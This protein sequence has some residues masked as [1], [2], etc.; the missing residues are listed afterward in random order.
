MKGYYVTLKRDTRTAWLLGPFAEHERA[1]AAV[2]AAFAKACQFDPRA[3]F[4]PIGTSSI[5]SDR[6]LPAGKL[7]KYLLELLEV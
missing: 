3:H 6:P 1:K 7:N 2:D 5:T 4:D